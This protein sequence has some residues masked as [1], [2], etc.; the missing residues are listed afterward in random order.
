MAKAVLA[1]RNSA[2]PAGGQRFGNGQGDHAEHLVL[3]QMLGGGN[4]PLGGVKVESLRGVARGRVKT[5]PAAAPVSPGIPFPPPAPAWRRRRG[6]AGFQLSGG[7][8]PAVPDL[9]GGG[10]AAP[11]EGFPR[12]PLAK[13][14]K[15]LPRVPPLSGDG[16]PSGSSTLSPD[17][18]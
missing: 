3:I 1:S 8:A 6:F 5:N 15:R 9:Q 14:G 18:A 13:D 7:G 12:R 17:E 10:T 11:A 4:Q 2:V 16:F